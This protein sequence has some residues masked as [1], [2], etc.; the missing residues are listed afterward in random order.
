MDNL[1]WMYLSAWLIE[2]Q[3]HAV[4]GRSDVRDFLWV[5]VSMWPKHDL[6]LVC[7]ICI[8]E[9]C[10]ADGGFSCHGRLCLCFSTTFYHSTGAYSSSD[11][12]HI[13]I[14]W[15]YL[16]Y[17][18]AWTLYNVNIHSNCGTRVLWKSIKHLHCNWMPQY[19]AHGL[20]YHS[21]QK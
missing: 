10:P 5:G 7:S 6:A 18:P 1:V 21:I 20:N 4:T 16:V 11:C 17:G 19:D 8:V 2:Y 13:Y 9:R 3:Y 12:T 14:I 15:I